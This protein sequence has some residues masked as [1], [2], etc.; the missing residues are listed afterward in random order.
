MIKI[1]RKV[2]QH[3]PSTL[4]VSLPS[5]WAKKNNIKK[6]DELD[7]KENGNEIIINPIQINPKIERISYDV[8]GMNDRVIRWLLSSMH[9]SGFDE[10]EITYKSPEVIRI[11]HELIRDLFMGFIIADQTEKRCILKSISQ[12]RGSEYDVSLRRAFLVTIAM[13]KSCLEVL[14]EGHLQNLR[15]LISLEESNNQLTNFCERILNKALYQKDQDH[16][17]GLL[18]VIPWNLEKVCDNYKYI[19][20]FLSEEENDDIKISK[21]VLSFFEKTNKFVEG[22]YN[23]FYKFEANKLLDLSN[24]RKNLIKISREIF[25][26]GNKHENIIMSYLTQIIEKTSDFSSTIAALNIK[27]VS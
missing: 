21:S 19:C 8:T 13:G 5:T 27:S 22:Y 26:N 16:R 20:E 14:K 4:I 12:D 2:V 10:I 6:G 25:K 15:D 7:V 11:V 24:E 23:L 9:K 3:G 17:I 1:K 18:Y